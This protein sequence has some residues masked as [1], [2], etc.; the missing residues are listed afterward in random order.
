MSPSELQNSFPDLMQASSG[1]YGRFATVYNQSAVIQYNFYNGFLRDIDVSFDTANISL[2][3]ATSNFD[4]IQTMLSRDYGQ[5][6]QYTAHTLSP[7]GAD[8]DYRTSEKWM[9]LVE[10]VHVLSI[11]NHKPNEYFYLSLGG[12]LDE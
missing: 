8:Q 2:E 9:G 5:M 11:K 1:T 10:I 12:P 6:P 7:T 4:L 3:Q